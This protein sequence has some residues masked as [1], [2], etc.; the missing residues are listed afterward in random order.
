MKKTYLKPT[1]KVVTLHTGKLFI[2]PASLKV[3]NDKAD[4]GGW[5]KRFWGTTILDDED[6]LEEDIDF[7]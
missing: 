4:E 3:S 1:S 6:A 2:A 7:D 5:S